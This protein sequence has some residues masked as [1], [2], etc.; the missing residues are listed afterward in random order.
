[1]FLL[2]CDIAVVGLIIY[3]IVYLIKQSKP[4]PISPER[5]AEIERIK[6]EEER[7]L[8]EKR[9]KENARKK[10]LNDRKEFFNT[11]E[12][13]VLENVTLPKTCD[14]INKL[15]ECIEGDFIIM[16]AAGCPGFLINL[17]DESLSIIISDENGCY[18]HKM[19]NLEEHKKIF[20]KYISIIFKY[21]INNIP[22]HYISWSKAYLE[23]APKHKPLANTLLS[24]KGNEEVYSYFENKIIDTDI[25][26]GEELLDIIYGVLAYNEV[27]IGNLKVINL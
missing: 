19:R 12:K 13:E 15:K 22:P 1:M 4:E 26:V 3:G 7:K 25:D 5:Q 14:H 27:N 6:V 8:E 11:L 24:R 17:L 9:E 21:E 23:S 10:Y 2:L 16:H 18:I 20:E